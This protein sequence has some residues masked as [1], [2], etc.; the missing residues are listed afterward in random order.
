MKAR[1]GWLFRHGFSSVIAVAMLWMTTG[2]VDAK[3]GIRDAFFTE[4]P[5]ATGTVLDTVPSH[6]NHCGVCHY[7]FNGGGTRNPFGAQVEVN[8]GSGQNKNYDVAVRLAAN[9]DS[10]GDGFTNIYEVTNRIYANAPTFPGL[11]A[12]N[13]AQ[14][15]NVSQGDLTPHLTPASGE[16]TTDPAVHVL[17]PNGSETATG[18]APLTITWTATDA[19]G[20]AGITI[21]VSLDNGTTYTPI[22]INIPNSPGSYVWQVSNRPTSNALV[23]VEA[24]DNAGNDGADTSDAVFYI[25][26][27]NAFPTTLR[28]FD[29]PGSQPVVDAGLP[30]ANPGSCGTCHGNYNEAHEPYRNWLGSMMAHASHDPIFKANMAIAQQDAPDSGDLCLRC[31]NSRGW[32]DGRSTPTDGSQ[33]TAQD[34]FGVSCDLCHRLVD[35]VYKPGTSPA[36]DQEILNSLEQVPSQSGDGN[37]MYVFDPNSHRRGPFNDSVSPHSDLFSPFHREAALCGTCHNVSNPVF[38]RDGTNTEYVANAFDAPATNFSPEVLMPVERT[39]SEWFHSAYNTSNGVYAPQFAGNKNGGM[40]AT[41]QDCHLPD[42]LGHG[43]DTNQYPSVALRPNLPL[44]DMTGGSVW[45]PRLLPGLPG[46]PYAPGSAEAQAISNGTHRAEYMLRKAARMQ[47]EKVGEQLKVLVI[48]DTGHKLPTGYPEGRRIWI[49]VRFYDGEDNLLAERGGYDGATG[50]LTNN[51]TVYE[52][53]PGIGTNLAAVLNTVNTNLAIEPGPSFHFV[54]NNQVYEDNRIPPRGFS[55][56]AFETFGGAPAGHHYADGQYWDE[57]FF[58]LPEGAES[59]HVRL[60]YQSTSKEFVEFL[61]NENRTTAA[62][63]NLYNLW[64]AN[65][66]CPPELMTEAWWP[67][68]FSIE[69]LAWTVDEKLG[70]AFNAVSGYTYWIEYADELGSNTVWQSFLGNGMLEA[71]GSSGS[72]TDDFT[73]ATSGGQ[74]T[75]GNRYYRIRR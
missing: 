34:M 70:V 62:G 35:P 27:T 55:N 19:S 29:Q 1:D 68:N 71:F 66:R 2:H 44:H 49:N 61:L 42:I 60:Y 12:G 20:I 24:I 25:V 59:A 26:S 6:A 18:N 5:S 38:V 41:C 3:P 36:E 39:Y 72:F 15:S 50:L 47:A 63:T 33:M 64:V 10:D 52:I 58:D 11:S 56:E 9:Y 32:L 21:K 65:D 16:D 75:G 57:T 4:Y 22:A 48:N 67:E 31:H 37:G 17:A 30:Q 45:L 13:V 7:D 46:F 73:E 40:V 51:T 8:V 23:K 43:A 69:A 28:D 53:H 14:V 74:P 54:L